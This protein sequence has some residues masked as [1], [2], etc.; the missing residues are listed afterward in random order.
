MLDI[1]KMTLTG[2]EDVSA[3]EVLAWVDISNLIAAEA[4]RTILV[5]SIEPQSRSDIVMEMLAERVALAN[6][7]ATLVQSTVAE[8]RK[9]LVE[10]KR[11]LEHHRSEL[12]AIP[13]RMEA[14]EKALM[15]ELHTRY[16]LKVA[17]LEEGGN[18]LQE[19]RGK[20]QAE[21]VDLSR[22]RD[23]ELSALSNFR[24]E[25]DERRKRLHDQ[26][27]AAA[28]EMRELEQQLEVLRAK[29]TSEKSLLE[30][31]TEEEMVKRKKID[32]L[33]EMGAQPP[34]RYAS[35]HGSGTPTTAR[36]I[37]G[38][39]APPT[40]EAPGPKEASK[41]DFGISTLQSVRD[42][43]R[44]IRESSLSPI[45]RSG[46]QSLATP[47]Q[48][49]EFDATDNELRGAASAS[50]RNHDIRIRDPSSASLRGGVGA[51]ASIASAYGSSPFS[52]PTVN[53]WK[54][55][56]RQLQ[57]DLQTLRSDLGAK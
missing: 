56:L 55:R 10:V 41:L 30:T 45:R 4:Q 20:L 33:V 52:S 13:A 43:L 24:N 31:L 19:V 25:S 37:G 54:E 18:K 6:K 11:E 39:D 9:A 34:P 50:T 23:E 15:S 46:S 29:V 17:E 5:A 57:G 14:K 40:G 12:Q 51:S 38:G 49:Q 2:G 26:K 28:E 27:I 42:Q 22:R 36:G 35:H 47:A 53:P 8:A 21:V 16:D 48:L 1:P 7:Y 44:E 32:V 3:A